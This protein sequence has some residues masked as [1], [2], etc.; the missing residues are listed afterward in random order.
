MD[1]EREVVV[2]PFPGV[3]WYEVGMLPLAWFCG[4]CPIHLPG[5]NFP[6]ERW[7]QELLASSAPAAA[8]GDKA[9]SLQA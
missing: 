6:S 1:I 7:N 8:P 3:C 4:L 5:L 9:D 2:A